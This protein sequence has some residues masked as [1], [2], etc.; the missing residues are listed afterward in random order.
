MRDVTYPTVL[1]TAIIPMPIAIHMPDPLCA[2]T[3]PKA[4]WGLAVKYH[5]MAYKIQWT[6]V[7]VNALTNVTMAQVVM[8]Y[9]VAGEYVKMAYV[10]VLIMSLE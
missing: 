2:E 6:V 4:R 1:M 9:A 10:I 7:Y 3:V 5:V 8:L